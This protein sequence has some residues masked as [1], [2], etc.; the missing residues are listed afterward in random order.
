MYHLIH[1]S[2]LDKLFSLACTALQRKGANICNLLI[3]WHHVDNVV[4]ATNKLTVR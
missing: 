3:F 2:K 1:E 4:R